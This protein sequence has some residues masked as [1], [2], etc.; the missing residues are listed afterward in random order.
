MSLLTTNDKRNPKTTISL[1]RN[2]YKS[3]WPSRDLKHPNLP[4]AQ[5][6][7]YG[8]Y[9]G[10]IVISRYLVRLRETWPAM[11]PRPLPSSILLHCHHHVTL[12]SLFLS[13]LWTKKLFLFS[14]YRT[15]K[16]SFLMICYDHIGFKPN[17][18]ERMMRSRSPILFQ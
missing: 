17:P 11:N 7:Y 18:H 1:S 5:S 12:L 13:V 4:N 9:E 3:T 14:Y 16:I 15:R 6:N 10:N 8:A 2:I